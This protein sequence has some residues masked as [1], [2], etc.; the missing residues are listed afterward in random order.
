M[1]KP[2]GKPRGRPSSKPKGSLAWQRARTWLAEARLA[3]PIE[4]KKR[5]PRNVAPLI[6]DAVIAKHYTA[7]VAD[8]A[9]SKI[10]VRTWL[11]DVCGDLL[12]AYDTGDSEADDDLSQAEL[13]KWSEPCR[14]IVDACYK[15]RVHVPKTSKHP[16]MSVALTPDEC[17]V[18]LLDEA[19]G[20]A[21]KQLSGLE[22]DL[23]LLKRLRRLMRRGGY[24][25]SA[26]A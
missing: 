20:Y 1:S 23:P 9:M 22:H 26:V 8:A 16:A 12:R 3:L 24:R 13:F 6:V 11:M 19:I 5:A 25:R 10:A 18:E 15:H 2:T 14:R 21:E 17:D 4:T 7:I